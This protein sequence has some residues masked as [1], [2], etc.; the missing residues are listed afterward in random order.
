MRELLQCLL[1]VQ[2]QAMTLRQ[3]GWSLRQESTQ[4]PSTRERREE[5]SK[6][7]S[8]INHMDINQKAMDEVEVL[9]EVVGQKEG[10][11]GGVQRGPKCQAES[12]TQAGHNTRHQTSVAGLREFGC[13]S[14]CA[15]REQM[16][17]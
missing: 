2:R 3:H 10:P 6:E 16:Q 17:R 1:S 7:V 5:E 15:H 14:S 13:P 4:Q 12:L 11:E 9:H 8:S